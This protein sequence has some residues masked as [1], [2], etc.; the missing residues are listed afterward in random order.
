MMQMGK[1]GKR[2]EAKEEWWDWDGKSE[3]KTGGK[4]MGLTIIYKL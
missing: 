3:V 2:N 4:N 1:N